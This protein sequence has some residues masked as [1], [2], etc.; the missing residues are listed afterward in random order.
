MIN[1]QPAK[2]ESEA[3]TQNASFKF[4]LELPRPP[5]SKLFV[6]ER[7]MGRFDVNPINFLIIGG[8]ETKK[9]QKKS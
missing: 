7:L 6:K 2:V 4:S 8:I 9:G 3:K 1:K 5:I